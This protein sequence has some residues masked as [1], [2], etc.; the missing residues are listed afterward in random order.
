[1][2]LDFMPSWRS[3]PPTSSGILGLYNLWR[4]PFFG[5]KED[6]DHYGMVKAKDN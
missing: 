1:M 3:I 2:M 4:K 5:H 6:S